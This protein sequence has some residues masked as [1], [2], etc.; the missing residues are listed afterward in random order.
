MASC[1]QTFTMRTMR[2]SEQHVKPLKDGI[3]MRFDFGDSTDAMGDHG[4]NDL[5]VPMDGGGDGDLAALVLSLRSSLE[6]W[7]P[8][9]AFGL[10]EFRH[11]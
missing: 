2:V 1:V 8:A 4:S 10:P 9:S 3:N 5:G 7:N 6:L 11:G